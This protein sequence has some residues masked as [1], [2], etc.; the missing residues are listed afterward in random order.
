[1]KTYLAA[2]KESALL[3]LLAPKRLKSVPP[4]ELLLETTALL[5]H[6]A[7]WEIT[8]FPRKPV[9][10]SA[11]AQLLMIKQLTL[12]L[13]N[14]LPLHPVASRESALPPLFVP[15]SLLN[16]LLSELLLETTALLTLHAASKAYVFLQK[17]AMYLSNV[18]LL[19]DLCPIM[20]AT[21][22]YPAAIMVSA[23]PR[24]HVIFPLLLLVVLELM[25]LQTLQ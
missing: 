11:L 3:P 13:I 19:V 22:I 1:M 7:A 25:G 23:L 8:V 4:T 20:A 6:L 14:A 15:K 21:L 24:K 2:N 16:V 17:L 10:N 5:T 18:Q 12:Q 9:R